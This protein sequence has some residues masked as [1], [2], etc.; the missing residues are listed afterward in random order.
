MNR[1]IILL[2]AN[3]EV[4]FEAVLLADLVVAVSTGTFKIIKDRRVSFETKF[5]RDTDYPLTDL[6]RLMG[7][8]REHT[9]IVTGFE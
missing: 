7:E 3:Q 5:R 9:E 8:F 4:P 6:P 1:I 2:S